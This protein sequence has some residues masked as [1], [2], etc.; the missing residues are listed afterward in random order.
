MKLLKLGFQALILL[1]QLT[2]AAFVCFAP[3]EDRLELGEEA[4]LWLLL[5]PVRLFL[6]GFLLSSFDLFRK[7]ELK[8]LEVVGAYAGVATAELIFL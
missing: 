6:N 5:R 1:G 2:A 3:A 8:L 4:L 7:I